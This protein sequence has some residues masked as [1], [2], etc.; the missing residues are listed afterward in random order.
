MFSQF[1]WLLKDLWEGV[2]FHCNWKH[3]KQFFFNWD[4]LHAKLNS[5]CEAWSYKK[6]RHKKVREICLEITY[7]KK[8]SFNSRLKAT[9]IIGLVI[10][11]FST[12]LQ[13]NVITK[14][15][16]WN[17]LNKIESTYL[18]MFHA[19][20]LKSLL[21]EVALNILIIKNIPSLFWSNKFN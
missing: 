6:K 20:F 11:K 15:S 5:H 8:V 10:F 2:H 7:S 18:D 13:E 3:P 17:D 14:V 9:K 1:L 16:S 4:S 12:S 19:S 21:I